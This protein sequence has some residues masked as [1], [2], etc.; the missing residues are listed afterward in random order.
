MIVPPQC[1]G[2]GSLSLSKTIFTINVHCSF[3]LCVTG[4]PLIILDCK[5]CI[6]LGPLL[7]FR[8]FWLNG[9][10]LSFFSIK[11]VRSFQHVFR[12]FWHSFTS[13]SGPAFLHSFSLFLTWAWN[14]YKMMMGIISTNQ[15]FCKKRFCNRPWCKLDFF[16]YCILSNMESIPSKHSFFLQASRDCCKCWWKV[17]RFHH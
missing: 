17:Q 6:P 7:R 3:R 4:W 1:P 16:V 15:K 10:V 11:S 2:A 14:G 13:I 5:N 12:S 9:Q 8:A